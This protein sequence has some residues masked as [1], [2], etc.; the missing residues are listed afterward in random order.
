MKCIYLLCEIN[1]TQLWPGFEV[2]HPEPLRAGAQVDW[3]SWGPGCHHSD[4]C[5]AG[6]G[7]HQFWNLI[8]EL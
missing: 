6:P 7:L 8:G 1:I 3:L 5:E 4:L 2:S